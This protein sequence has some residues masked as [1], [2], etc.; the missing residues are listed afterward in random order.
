M[1]D[2]GILKTVTRLPVFTFGAHTQ[3]DR[4]LDDLGCGLDLPPHRP[5]QAG[6]SSLLSPCRR[7][8][9]DAQGLP[10]DVVEDWA[11]PLPTK[12]FHRFEATRVRLG[13]GGGETF[14]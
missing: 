10:I 2:G 7:T 1:H 11:P 8:R 13:G 14:H 4:F 9:L 12:T 6:H 5:T 3:R